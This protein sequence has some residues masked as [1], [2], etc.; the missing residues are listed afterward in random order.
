MK[1]I[2]QLHKKQTPFY[3]LTLILFCSIH[4]F[5]QKR[6][7]PPLTVPTVASL[8]TFE[9]LDNGDTINRT[10]TK[11]NKYGKWV[12][13]NKGGYG[14]DD[15]MENGTFQNSIK[16]G[17]WKIYDMKGVLM[18]EEFFR[19]GNKDGEAKYYDEG[20]LYC[21][22]HYLALRS[23]YEYDTILVQ[24]PVTEL[25]K[26]VIIKTDVGSVRH[27]FW[28]FYDP[29]ST[30]VKRV[31]EYQADEIIYEKEYPAKVDSAYIKERMRRFAK[32]EIKSDAMMNQKGRKPPKFTD[33]PE[34]T[35]YVK[36]NVR[37]KK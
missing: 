34:N 21:V 24:D 12:I 1:N 33:F 10:D 27:G 32:G 25:E 35:E 14:E 23:K 31:V 19:Q 28:T 30:Q 11:G 15:Y 36:P 20:H 22:G 16:T 37:Q 13:V 17:K 4:S 8:A 7:T 18:S 29:P 6:K 2:S 9:L 5:A 3:I 26:P